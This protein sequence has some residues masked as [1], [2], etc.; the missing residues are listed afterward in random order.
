MGPFR[1]CLASGVDCLYAVGLIRQW[2]DSADLGR[3][4]IND[5]MD[6]GAMRRGPLSIDVKAVVNFHG[7]PSFRLGMFSP[8]HKPL[9]LGVTTKRTW[10]DRFALSFDRSVRFG[11][12]NGDQLVW[13]DSL[14][15][16]KP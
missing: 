1:Q 4:R 11:F 13:V 5:F 16:L 3:S 7:G 10:H 2:G 9:E 12:M 14:G 8:H 6:P 15:H